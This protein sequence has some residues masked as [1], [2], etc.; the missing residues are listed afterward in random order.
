MRL[1]GG[2]SGLLGLTVS[3]GWLATVAMLPTLNAARDEKVSFSRDILP[4]LSDKCFKCH[5]P[6]SGSRMA[7]MRLDIPQGAFADRGGRWPI[8]PSKPE[9]SLVVKR[10]NSADSPMPPRSSGK[11]LTKAEIATITRW[12][13]EGAH[14]G[15]LWSF[16]ELP[17]RVP[18]PA[19]KSA[20]PR[21]DLDRFIL[22]RLTHEGL[23]P[24]PEAGR[25]RWLRRV[26][27]D[28]TGLPPTEA[29][30][31]DFESDKKSGAYERVVDRLLASPHFGERIAV[32]WLDAARYSDSYGYQSD[33]LMP[34]W[35]YRDWVVR[36]FNDNLPYNQFLTDQ[37]AGDLLP[38]PTQDQR[39][40]T[41][42][43]R[44]HR[45]SN[46]GGS[47]ALEFKTEYAVD[48]VST[49]GTAVL[50]LTLGCARC[51]DHK[52]DPIS[53]REFYQLFGYFNSIDEYGLLL[54]TEIVPTPSLLLPTVDQAKKLKELHA[55]NDAAM[56][57]LAKATADA[58]PRYRQWLAKKP[59]TP[60]IPDLVAKFPL[61]N[62]DSSKFADELGG[63]AFGVKLGK[64]DLVDGKKGKGVLFDGDN[65][66][67]LKGLPGRERWDAFT[68]SF[69]IN[70]PRPSAGP[71]I[72][73][74]R[75]GGT[76]VGFCGFDM[77]L[78][79]GHLTARVMRHWPG[80]AVGIRTKN[81]IAKGSW[82]HVAWSW[83]GSGRAA[84]LK[85]YLGGKPAE[86]TVLN[87]ALWKKINAY[88][89]L[90]A[91]GGEWCFGERFR[92]A[93][94]KGG[95]LDD[96]AFAG[97]ALSPL[98]VA[99][100]FDGSSLANAI[101]SPG[102]KDYYVAAV[103][104]PA[105]AAR[106]A[107]KKLQVALANFEEAIQEI[108]VMAEAPQQIPA[109]VL[110][111]GAYD[112]PRTDA[113]KVVRGVPK[114]L[115]ALRPDGR[116]DRLSLAKWATQPNHP[117][118]ARVAVNRLWQLMFGAGLVETSEN[119]GVQGSQPTHP[120]LLDYLARRFVNSGWNVKGMLRSLALSA[121]YRQDSAR[122]AK[123]MQA[124][125]LNKLYARGPSQR[126]SAEMV[127]D[128]VLSAS[129][130]LNA[131]IGGPPVNPYQPAGIWSEN[132]TMSPGFVQSK[133]A[134][135]YR[136]S[137][138]STW[139]RTTPVPSMMLFDAT[140]REACTMRRQSTNTP[141]QA[142]VLLNDVQ[143]V[144]A[145]R[146]LAERVLTR[147]QSDEERIRSL[148]CRLASREPDAR[149][150]AVLMQTLKE[151]RA[152][153]AADPKAAA[154]LIAVGETKAPASLEPVELASMTVVVQTALNSDSVIWKR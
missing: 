100:L 38:N 51:H 44:L 90:G 28:L 81:R 19:V 3:V 1:G 67:A 135:L 66:I 22:A 105:R 47:I 127:R 88:G 39:L 43:N 150:V 110:A 17:A 107:V 4:L 114:S 13:A 35:P 60:A 144:E 111:R 137:L 42:F 139:K 61:D 117:L 14:Y 112:A 16:E 154:K 152:Q 120:E 103:D 82:E 53:Q 49:F 9:D 95:K 76:D 83:D 10:I 46:E 115:P 78:E 65:G 72:L 27:L 124:D 79:D 40:A 92:D 126:L 99:Q 121:T 148:F 149:E 56:R 134:D 98:E 108:S 136:R 20:W 104:E 26:T 58:E 70:D 118:T 91:S 75:T 63:K 57:D 37:L 102:L 140:S 86:T 68:W 74:H 25:L 62:Y 106:A 29:E 145:A 31:A 5:G 6:D 131:K 96:L 15:K 59:A 69:W 71:V 73:M 147:Q 93:G 125:P 146:V 109:Y 64:V 30:A 113:T 12:I 138:Y 8:V 21:D 89:D 132:N 129:G 116:N 122:T 85:I 153:F 7:N 11:S 23:A 151:Q 54:S 24:S 36:A 55:Q 133:G 142:L 50:G 52:F 33:L 141:L 101:D 18:V 84:G 34:T 130:L 87:D 2:V 41:A 143:F 97:R 94:F 32:D 119:F 77:M 123:L 45:Q 128:T 80:N 48:R